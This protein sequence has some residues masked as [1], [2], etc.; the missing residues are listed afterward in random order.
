MAQGNID[1]L[2]VYGEVR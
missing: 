2:I 1:R